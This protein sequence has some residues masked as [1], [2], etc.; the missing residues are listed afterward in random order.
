MDATTK[1]TGLEEIR[2]ERGKAALAA[3][4]RFDKMLQ[5]TEKKGVSQVSLSALRRSFDLC[6]NELGVKAAELSAWNME[7]MG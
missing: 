7:V 6:V 1:N 3:L 5:A 2:S 4:I